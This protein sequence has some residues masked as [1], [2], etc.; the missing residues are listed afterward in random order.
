MA[1]LVRVRPFEDP[2]LTR[3]RSGKGFRFVEASGKAIAARDRD[4]IDAL[5]IPPAWTEVWIACDPRGHIQVVGTDDAGRKQYIYHPDWVQKRDR[6]KYVRAL[7]LA[8]AMPRARGRVTQSLRRE[9]LERERV[10]ALA[11]RLLDVV[12]PR[13]GSTRYL[14]RHGSRGLTTLQRRHAAL[15]EGVITLSFPA[16]SGQRA[17]LTVDDA[18]AIEVLT[19]L[20]AGRPRSALLSYQRGR[21]RVSLTPRDV[22]D[23]VRALTGGAFTA[24]DFRTLHGTIIAAQTLAQIGEVATAKERTEAERL[25]VRATSEALGNTVAVARRSYIDPRVFQRYSE[26][27]LLSLSGAR[28]SALLALLAR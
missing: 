4:R 6:S 8:E 9:G 3:T 7:A 20:A 15:S 11:F 23:Y 2:G 27:R 10:L 13:V 12:A 28:E 21:R 25:A 24:K 5:V 1:K 14:E 17:L 22:N 18:D 16:K 19:L 26:G